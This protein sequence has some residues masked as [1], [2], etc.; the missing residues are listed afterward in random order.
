MTV[1]VNDWESLQSQIPS[2]R[3]IFLTADTAR[4][5]VLVDRL[6]ERIEITDEQ[7]IIRFKINLNDF[8]VQ[9]RISNVNG[10]PESGL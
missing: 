2:W 3:E 10:V 1:S 9:P 8:F 4:K 7:V 5:R 6:I